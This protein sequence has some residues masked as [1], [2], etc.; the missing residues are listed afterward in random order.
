MQIKVKDTKMHAVRFTENRDS[1]YYQASSKSVPVVEGKLVMVPYNTDKPLNKNYTLLDCFKPIIISETEKIEVGDLIYHRTGKFILECI[2]RD[3][4]YIYHK[5]LIDGTKGN[6]YEPYY[7]KAL[8]S[9]EQFSSKHLQAIVD[10]KMKDGDKV[11]V[12][13]E[14]GEWVCYDHCTPEEKCDKYQEQLIKLSSQGHVTLYRVEEKM[15]TIDD[16]KDIVIRFCEWK[17]GNHQ[18]FAHPPYL[19]DRWREWLD[20]NIK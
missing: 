6:N 14:K 3:E 11:L 20:R 1:M 7:H 18:S 12:E 8:V 19:T 9:P 5:S 13:C 16:V 2:K 4:V 15:Y 10:G 17:Y